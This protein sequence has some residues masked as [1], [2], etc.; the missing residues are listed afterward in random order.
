[1]SAMTIRE[2]V[3][4]TGP[5]MAPAIRLLLASWRLIAIVTV[6]A[7][8]LGAAAA[9]LMPKKYRGDIITMP[10]MDEYGGGAGQ[11]M[12]SMLSQ[13]GGLA[14]LVGL[15]GAAS[16]M[17]TEAIAT[18]ESAS[19]SGRFIEENHLLPILYADR[20]DAANNR[21]KN[22]GQPPSLWRANEQFRRQVRSVVENKKS[23]L[24]TVSV[25]WTDARQAAEWANGLVALTNRYMRGKAIAEAQRNIA[26]LK[27]QA[28][29]TD[30]VEV[31]ASIYSL[32][33]AETKRVMLA[34]G[35]EE[36]ALRVIDQAVTPER[37]IS[38]RRVLWIAA[39]FVGGL[40]LS[41][42]VVLLVDFLR[43][44]RVLPGRSE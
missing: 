23:G 12:S 22:A 42:C 40:L 26:Y 39:S 24:V 32:M 1:M 30:I 35:R 31:R 10:T 38:P 18:L 44:N 20:W 43:R 36:Y 25:V 34:N 41:V 27:D 4:D 9:W 13:F 14:S 19:L 11:A 37:E 5:A 17:K 21:W 28:T 7:T 16:T 15:P 8:L 33:E 3:E 2:Q 6:L 29:K